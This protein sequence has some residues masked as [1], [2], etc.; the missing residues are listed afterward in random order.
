MVAI[1][2]IVSRCGLTIEVHYRNVTS[3]KGGI[4]IIC[5]LENDATLYIDTT[6]PLLIVGLNLLIILVYKF[7]ISY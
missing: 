7:E 1:V 4:Q 5:T 3:L 2:G 6:K